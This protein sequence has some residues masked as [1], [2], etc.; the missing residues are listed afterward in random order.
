[1]RYLSSFIIIAVFLITP[2]SLNYLGISNR[3]YNKN[4]EIAVIKEPHQAFLLWQKNN[5]KGRILFHFDRK[6]N[7]QDFDKPL[8]DKN[9]IYYAVTNNNVRKVYHIVPEAS[10]SDLEGSLAKRYN[11]ARH[12]D[13][14]RTTVNGTPIFI[15]RVKDIEKINEKVLVNI[16]GR[17]WDMQEISEIVSLMKNGTLNSDYVTVPEAF[18]DK[19]LR[20]MAPLYGK[21]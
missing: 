16:D 19:I 7:I 6:S 1:M 10:W 3:A 20:E 4:R 12:G 9:Y 5:L 11:V 18:S 15:M 13:Y 2:L 8:S 17:V 21:H 14:F